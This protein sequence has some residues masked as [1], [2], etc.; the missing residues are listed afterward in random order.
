MP[1]KE[2]D[3]KSLVSRPIYYELQIEILGI[4]S[5]R[6]IIPNELGTQF[7]PTNTNVGNGV[8]TLFHHENI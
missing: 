6:I 1:V 5:N 8:I 7:A 3:R 4:F 2:N